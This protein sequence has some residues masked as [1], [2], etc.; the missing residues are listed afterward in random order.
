M[1]RLAPAA[2]RVQHTYRQ[3]R[4]PL[5][6]TIQ[7]SPEKGQTG[8][9]DRDKSSGGDLPG[10]DSSADRGISYSRYGNKLLLFAGS[11]RSLAE[12]L[13]G[14]GMVAGNGSDNGRAKL[15]CG[16]LLRQ[17]RLLAGLTQEALA[18][19][20]G[21]SADYIR[22]LERGRRRPPPEALDRLAGALRLGESERVVLQTALER[23]DDAETDAGSLAGRTREMTE[24][25]RLLAGLG[26]SV[27]L[28]SG[29]PGMG[30]THLLDEAV[31]VA[32]QGGWRVVR[33]GCRR[34]T[35]DPY[36]PLTDA[37]AESLRQL[38]SSDREAALRRAGKLGLLLPEHADPGNGVEPGTEAAPGS[39][40]R[41]DQERRLL[42]AAVADYL[43]AVAGEQGVLLVL[44]DLQWAGPDALDLLTSLV[45]VARPAPLGLIGAYN[46]TPSETSL[47]G[48]VADLARAS[49]VQVL[50]LD[51]L[52]DDEATQLV[53]DLIPE[54]DETRRALL[55]AIVRRAGGVP[56]FLVSFVEDLRERDGGEPL[57]D[58][59]WTVVQVIR[60]RMVALPAVAR[61]LLGVAAVV[62]GVIPRTVLEEISGRTEEDMLAALEAAIDAHLLEEEGE[63]GYR[64]RHDLIRETIEQDLSAGRRRM[65]HRRIGEALEQLPAQRR[66]GRIAEIAWH[67]QQ[68]GDPGRALPW[69]LK[70]GNRAAA[71]SA[72]GESEMRYRQAAD[73]ARE[74]GDAAAEAEALDMLGDVLYRAGRY[75]DAADA[76]ERAEDIYERLDD[77]DRYLSTV[78]R[79][80]DAYGFAGRATEGI[81]RVLAAI[82]SLEEGGSHA[83]PS[84]RLAD[85]YAALCALYL[86]AGRWQDGLETAEVAVSLAEKT[87]N[88]RALCTAEISRGL[89]L[90]ITNRV[91]EQR[92]AFQRAAE[93]AE[94][95][96]DQSLAALAVYHH[97]VSYL[98]ADEI[99]PGEQ[100]VRR[101][102]DIAERAGL[103]GWATF[104]RHSLADLLVMHGR[105]TEG[106]AEAERAEAD[107]RCL[108]ARPGATYP[109]ISLG[110]IL[111][112]QGE[113]EAGLASLHEALDL[114]MRYQYVPGLRGAQETLAWQEVRDGRPDEAITRLEPLV[115]RTRAVGRPW[116]PTVYG[117][118]LLEVG[119]EK[120]AAK[121]LHSAREKEGGSSSRAGLP[122]VLL[123]TASLALRQGRRSDAGLDLDE[124]IAIARELGLPYDEAL[125]LE[126]HSQVH[127]AAG[128]PEQARLRLDEALAIFQRLGALP[129][130][131]RVE[132]GLRDLA[133]AI[134]RGD[135]EH[136][137]ASERA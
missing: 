109:L 45:M 14:G 24:I 130:V 99:E 96:G 55:P 22:K 10:I 85:L 27:L 30:K 59:P 47:G 103:V 2:D 28:L 67:F 72:Q 115:D 89:A 108:G 57:S 46:T 93:I 91:D 88:L 35:Q 17:Y 132:H 54:S 110:R 1:E 123:Q 83:P 60:Q 101:A 36:D 80:G 69:M 126:Q 48:F 53:S 34:R 97:G 107:S 38:S 113:R 13:Q 92:L 71:L 90:G 94:P 39:T 104:A 84:A 44:D 127:A 9:N 32:A 125:L 66:E 19:G 114:A 68:G 131:E 5:L 50:N 6:S 137:S 40:L 37:L 58:L 33:G 49:Q 31:A 61:E 73:L 64:F 128:E 29:E 42:F 105:W 135:L 95:Q 65:L 129:D 41:P 87:G 77:R 106:R 116:Y 43:Q 25:R 4:P 100:H 124:G 15:A 102:L 133:D 79:S 7:P 52:S 56:L 134:S 98:L 18:T 26:P 78:A 74:V 122:D 136:G 12:T 62:G 86:H 81:D 118:A 63:D 70:A 20:S 8:T 3:S 21:Y 111:L 16:E 119:D 11:I 76:L 82:Q 23:P 117:R 51:P 121:V 112:L 120:R 75:G